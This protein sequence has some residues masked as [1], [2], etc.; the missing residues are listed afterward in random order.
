MLRL[1][2]F[3]FI[4]NFGVCECIYA[5]ECGQMLSHTQI[6]KLTAAA[7]QSNSNLLQHMKSLA[8][9][10]QGIAGSGV[11]SVKLRGELDRVSWTYDY[12]RE[13]QNSLLRAEML[14]Q[15]R[16]VMRDSRDKQIVQQSLSIAAASTRDL[17]RTVYESV[18]ELLASLNR[19]GIAVD[20]SRLRDLAN[21][22]EKVFESCE[23]PKM[24]EKKQ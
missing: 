24:L 11:S 7:R 15:I 20:V 4:L 1:V 17:S 16:D 2:M 19:P 14:A 18:N 23:L 22:T 13:L 3:S 6:S 8:T 10:W 21:E 5:A 9:E 12:S